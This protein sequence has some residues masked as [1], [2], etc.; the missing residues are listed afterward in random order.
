MAATNATYLDVRRRDAKFYVGRELLPAKR[1]SRPTFLDLSLVSLG[2]LLTQLDSYGRCPFH[3]SLFRSAIKRRTNKEQSHHRCAS[4]SSV[5]GRAEALPA[6]GF[7]GGRLGGSFPA[8]ASPLK[9][10]ES[11]SHKSANKKP[12][13]PFPAG[14]VGKSLGTFLLRCDVLHPAG[15]G[16][17]RLLF[18]TQTVFERGANRH[19]GITRPQ[20]GYRF[21]MLY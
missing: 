15:A 18:I 12:C 11:V 8:S 5:I 16:P 6:T 10:S 17:K 20:G 1:N 21:R 13:S 2:L 4:V 19:P 3:G 7:R 14:R 9:C